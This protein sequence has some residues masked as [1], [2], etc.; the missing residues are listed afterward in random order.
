[1]GKAAKKEAGVRTVDNNIRK[2][3]VGDENLA[4]H[5]VVICDDVVKNEEMV[6]LAAEEGAVEVM[7][8]LLKVQKVNAAMFTVHI[9]KSVEGITDFQRFFIV[10]QYRYLFF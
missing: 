6:H 10:M 3:E 5:G 7:I 1:M 2:D 9:Y 4:P 8:V